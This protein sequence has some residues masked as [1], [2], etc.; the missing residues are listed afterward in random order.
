MLDRAQLGKQIQKYFEDNDLIRE[1]AI[2]SEVNGTENVLD[3]PK[4]TLQ[5]IRDI[6]MG[7]YQLK[8]DPRY[9]ESPL[10]DDSY[11]LQ[12]C[13][14]RSNLLRVKL[15][16]RHSHIASTMW[17]LETPST[18]KYADS[19]FNGKDVPLETDSDSDSDGFIDE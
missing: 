9:T 2:Y 7:V 16:S 12:T 13:C 18:C 1:K 11:M 14:D 15:T 10:S 8:Q 17:D 19:N 6:T 3:F 5:Q 4:L